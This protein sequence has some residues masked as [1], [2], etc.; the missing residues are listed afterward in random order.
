MKEAFGNSEIL[1]MGIFEFID[2]D[3][4]NKTFTVINPHNPYAHQYFKAFGKQE[5][6]VC[7]YLRGLCAGSFQSFFDDDEM[8][9]I[10]L[11]CVA[12]G[13]KACVFR[14]KPLSK[15]DK[16][17]PAINKQIIKHKLPQDVFDKYYTWD[18]LV[19]RHIGK[20][21]DEKQR[22]LDE[23]RLAKLVKEFK[24]KRI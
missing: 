16:N 3:L 8:T 19:S 23:K 18:M 4:E 22:V 14:I 20:P 15:L 6:V 21:K 17:D 11:A 5:D 1:G 9:C 2:F 13:D 24:E 10:E 7:H 12:K